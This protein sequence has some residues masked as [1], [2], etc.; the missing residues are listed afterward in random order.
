MGVEP[1]TSGFGDLRSIQLSYK[2]ALGFRCAAEF[3]YTG[4][5]QSR[6]PLNYTRQILYSKR[7][8]YSSL[9][10][11]LLSLSYEMCFHNCLK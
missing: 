8:L 9:Q 10:C 11:K 5:V 3:R 1:M 2:H 4:F 6:P 7:D